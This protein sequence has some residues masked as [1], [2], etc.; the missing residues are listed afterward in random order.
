MVNYKAMKKGD[1]IIHLRTFEGGLE[2]AILD[3]IS[4]SA[5]KIFRTDKLIPDA[6][7]AYLRQTCD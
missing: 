2:C 1:F 7:K 5:Y 4:S 6:Y 3:E